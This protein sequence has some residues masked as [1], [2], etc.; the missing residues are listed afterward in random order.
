MTRSS[1]VLVYQ[2]A[3]RLFVPGENK[4]SLEK[5]KGIEN[6]YLVKRKKASNEVLL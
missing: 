5:E 3:G 1:C 6:Y 4:I 2:A